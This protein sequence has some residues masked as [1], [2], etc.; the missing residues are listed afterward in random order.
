MMSS[1]LEIGYCL[2]G[3][4]V[5]QLVFFVAMVLKAGPICFLVVDFA[6]GYGKPVCND[7][8]S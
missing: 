3:L 1:L 7:V 2:G 8:I 4:K 6:L 5:I